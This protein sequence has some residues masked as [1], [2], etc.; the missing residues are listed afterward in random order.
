MAEM[1]LI[2]RAQCVKCLKLFQIEG[3]DLRRMYG[4]PCVC[5]ECKK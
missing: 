4:H 3:Y 2:I 1:T 5:G